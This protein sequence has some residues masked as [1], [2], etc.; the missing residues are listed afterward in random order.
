MYKGA[1]SAT[2]G[3]LAVTEKKRL[4][5][6]TGS[7]LLSEPTQPGFTSTPDLVVTALRERALVS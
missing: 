4:P 3:G 7:L 5:D 2:E 1:S 6:L